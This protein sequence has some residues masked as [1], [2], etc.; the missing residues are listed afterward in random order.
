VKLE[1]EALVY[2]KSGW[3]TMAKRR[4]DKL[5]PRFYGLFQ[6]LERIGSVAYKLSLPLVFRVRKLRKEIPAEYHLQ[7]MPAPAALIE[8][9]NQ[10]QLEDILEL[11][12]NRQGHALLWAQL[13]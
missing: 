13:Q 11:C 12:Y 4:N 3:K 7:Q 5:S 10:P 1:Q 6:V 8:Y 9:C 2:L